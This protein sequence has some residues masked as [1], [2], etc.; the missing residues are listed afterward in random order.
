MTP[1]NIREVL[2]LTFP[3][4]AKWRLI[5]VQLGI[6]VGTLDAIEADRKMVGDC[7]IDLIKHWLRK[8]VLKPTR[9][10]LTSVLYSQ[11]C[12]SGKLYEP[13]CACTMT[14]QIWDLIVIII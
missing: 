13:R 5:G 10:A 8:T 3:H 6:D 4:R 7:L 1:D 9:G 14:L 11:C 2:D 12:T